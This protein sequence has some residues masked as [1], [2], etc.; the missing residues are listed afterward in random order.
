MRL[1]EAREGRARDCDG[2]VRAKPVQ[3]APMHIVVLGWL[4]VTF[5]MALTMGA[6]A[7]IAFFVV[8]GLAPVAAWAIVVARRRSVRVRRVHAGDDRHAEPDQ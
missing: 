2:I 8:V 3:R 4:Y 7:G 5:A 1:V 6:L